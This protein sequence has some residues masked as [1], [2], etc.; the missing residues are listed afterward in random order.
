MMRPL[1]GR[2]CL[3]RESVDL[4]AHTVSQ[5]AIDD[6]VALNTRFPIERSRDDYGLKVRTI[7]FD[8]K[9]VAIEFFAD[10]SLYCFWG[11]HGAGCN[12]INGVGCEALRATTGQ[13]GKNVKL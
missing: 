7:A 5:C 8:R 11:D 2:E 1:D 13:P 12:L 4:L 9:M 6:L 3:N 10:I